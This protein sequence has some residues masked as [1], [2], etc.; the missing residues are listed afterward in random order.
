MGPLGLSAL[1]PV[2]AGLQL[3]RWV[4]S[5]SSWLCLVPSLH[6]VSNSPTLWLHFLPFGH[7]VSNPLVSNP[8]APLTWLVSMSHPLDKLHHLFML[9]VR[10]PGLTM[11][12]M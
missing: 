11:L 7:Q 5:L 9:V 8:L 10:G 6:E 12:L 2:A 4:F 1:L 3:G